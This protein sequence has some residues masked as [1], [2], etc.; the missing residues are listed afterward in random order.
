MTGQ[1]EP[2]DLVGN[3]IENKKTMQKRTVIN[4]EKRDETDKNLKD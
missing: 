4:G 3:G 1:A 2:R